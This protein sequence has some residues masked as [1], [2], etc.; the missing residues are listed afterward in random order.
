MKPAATSEMDAPASVASVRSL[1]DA[2]KPQVA[3]H[4]GLLAH[5]VRI[6]RS[7]AHS[8]RMHQGD[9]RSSP[10]QLLV[11]V[12]VADLHISLGCLVQIVH[13]PDEHRTCAEV[14][15]RACNARQSGSICCRHEALTLLLNEPIWPPPAAGAGRVG[16]SADQVLLHN[17]PVCLLLATTA[18]VTAYISSQNV[19]VK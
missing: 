12:H 2:G 13:G 6:V 4:V 5:G 8:P 14:R 10:W 18:A 16:S 19:S 15:I 1:I 3:M 7:V 9:Q 11:E 17:V